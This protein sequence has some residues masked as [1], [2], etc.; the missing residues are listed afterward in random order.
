MTLRMGPPVQGRSS[1]A[2]SWG[3][4]A[5]L[6]MTFSAEEPFPFCHCEE[7]SDVAISAHERKGLGRQ[8]LSCA[9]LKDSQY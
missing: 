4:L 5:A 1:Q 2:T 9:S 3:F 7:R 6:E 8:N